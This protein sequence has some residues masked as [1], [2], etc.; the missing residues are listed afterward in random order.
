MQ[1]RLLDDLLEAARDRLEVVAG[2]A[3]VRRKPLREDEEVARVL[4]PRVVVHREKAADV[5]EPVLLR[6]HRAAVGEGEHLLRDLLR[7]AALLPLLAPLDEVRVLGEAAG[8][9]EEGLLEPVAEGA[10]AAEVLERDRL[11]AAGVVRDGDHDERNAV[12]V[13]LERLFEGRKIHVALERVEETRDAPFRDDEV[14]RLGALDLHVRARRV[15]VVVVRDDVALVEDRVE[16]DALG[17]APLVRR[18]DVLETRQLLHGVAKA[19]ERAAARV[20]LVAL[21]EGAPLRGRHRARAGVRQEVDEDVLRVEEEDVVSG[22]GDGLAPL[23]P[24]S[25]S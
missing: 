23:L 20:R 4:G 19:V 6:R 1:V 13:L 12:A 18:D 15:E 16:E 3:A 24:G 25:S 11:P 17:G 2:E 10:H 8:V 21:H 22:L 5:R 14:A 7:G 9:E